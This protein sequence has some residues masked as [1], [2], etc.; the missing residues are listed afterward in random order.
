MT[1]L[2]MAVVTIGGILVSAIF[3]LILIPSL[4]YYFSSGFRVGSEP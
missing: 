1:N 4:Y 2:A 3:T